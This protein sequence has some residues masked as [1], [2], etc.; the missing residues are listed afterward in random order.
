MG[1]LTA[2]TAMTL[3]N[4]S[5]GRVYFVFFNIP[6]QRLLPHTLAVVCEGGLI[7]SGIMQEQLDPSPDPAML[8]I[9]NF[10]LLYTKIPL[11][12]V[13]SFMGNL[14]QR[15]ELLA[16]GPRTKSILYRGIFGNRHKYHR[17]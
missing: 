4:M 6:S 12:C 9:D 14:A 7:T 17:G 11:C 2:L 5:I 8:D 1:L 13:S 16:T 15:H 3:I 10:S